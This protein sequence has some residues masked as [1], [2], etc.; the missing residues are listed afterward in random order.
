MTAGEDISMRRKKLRYR[1]WH[2]GTREMDLVLGPYAD[3]HTENMDDA[4]LDRLEALM[5]EEDPPL[6]KW[7]MGQ[8]TPPDHIDKAFLAEVIADHQARVEK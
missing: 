8:E 3:A 4:A 5:S 6:L 1:A 2:R 7:V